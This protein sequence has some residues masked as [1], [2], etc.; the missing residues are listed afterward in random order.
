MKSSAT[1]NHIKYIEETGKKNNLKNKKWCCLRDPYEER[2]GYLKDVRE[3]RRKQISSLWNKEKRNE[4]GLT[5]SKALAD[6]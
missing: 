6:L 5:H 2:E 1:E 3:L 4:G